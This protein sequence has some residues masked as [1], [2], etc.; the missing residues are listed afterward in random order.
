MAA[1]S[2]QLASVVVAAK[3]VQ[4]KS[5]VEKAGVGTR[6]VR[7]VARVNCAAIFGASRDAAA[8]AP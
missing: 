8:F 7:I 4:A 3:I 1:S 5:T 6:D 2:E